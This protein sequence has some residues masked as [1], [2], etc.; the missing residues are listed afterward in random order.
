[1]RQVVRDGTACAT[2]FSFLLRR[3]VTK[4]QISNALS[5]LASGDLS[6]AVRLAGQAVEDDLPLVKEAMEA[7][8]ALGQADGK[9]DPPPPEAAGFLRFLAAAPV[10]AEGFRTLREG[11]G[12]SQAEI[13]EMCGV[14]RAAVSDWERGK[15]SLPPAAIHALLGLTLACFNRAEPGPLCGRDIARLRKA[16]GIRQI[17]LAAELGV[18]E[19]AVRKWEKRGDQPLAPSTVRRIQP[20]LDELQARASAAP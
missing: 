12:I 7:A 2:I 3:R 15:A 8:F 16:L 9:G 4:R 6:K 10:A 11:L 18:S 5:A 17:D 13:A 19:I 1:L 20:R 14:S